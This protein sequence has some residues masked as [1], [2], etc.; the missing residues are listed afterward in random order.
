[1]AEY[2]SSDDEERYQYYD[3]DDDDDDDV[4]VD[5]GDGGDEI[6][7]LRSHGCRPA[8]KVTTCFRF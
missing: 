6:V 8:F 7:S 3:D 4:D 5:G 2:A 1:M